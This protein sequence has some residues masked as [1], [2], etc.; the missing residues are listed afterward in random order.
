MAPPGEGIGRQHG[1]LAV[2]HHLVR[3][4]WVG[5]DVV[6]KADQNELQ[7]RGLAVFVHVDIVALHV[8][9]EV[10]VRILVLHGCLVFQ[11]KGVGIFHEFTVINQ[12][13]HVDG[14]GVAQ[15][16]LADG[17]APVGIIED[18]VAFRIAADVQIAGERQF[19]IVLHAVLA[20]GDRAADDGAT[21]ELMVHADFAIGDRAAGD[22]KSAFLYAFLFIF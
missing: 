6:V 11:G 21:A 3:L 16:I 7:Q 19:G 8:A 22:G 5:G 2:H 9:P 15:P 12:I 20:L 17:D 14:R 4:L 10:Q 1:V 13:A 18:Q